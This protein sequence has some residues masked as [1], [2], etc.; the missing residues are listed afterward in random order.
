MTPEQADAVLRIVTEA[1][2]NAVRHGGA[3]CVAVTVSGVP[4]VV[5]VRDDGKGFMPGASKTSSGGGFGL[6]SMRER[7]EGV[8]AV[9]DLR[10][11]VGAGTTVEVRW[12]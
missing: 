6:T 10:S 3:S 9:F 7:A 12:P 1:F 11:E 8:G 4:L 5:Q 2:R